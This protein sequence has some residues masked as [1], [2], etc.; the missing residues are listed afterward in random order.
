MIKLLP[1]LKLKRTMW[2]IQA[3]CF[4]LLM[5][6]AGSAVA[7]VSEEANLLKTITGKILDGDGEA[8][9]GA[10]IVEKGTGNGV[11]SDIDGM[12][13]ITVSD[14]CEFLEISYVGYKTIEIALDG[15]TNLE[16]SLELDQNLLNEVTVIGYGSSRKSDLTG[17][18]SSVKG[19]DLN[20]L[21]VQRV[22]QA[23]QGRAAG[24]VVQNT[25]GA[26][27]GGTLI[28]VRGANSINGGNSALVVVDGLQGVDIS[29]INPNDIASV[30]VL[31]DASATAIY[32]A[33]GANGVILITTK[34]GAT[35]KSTIQYNFS[36]GFQQLGRKVDL[37]NPA[38]YARKANL[39]ASTQ[40]G[41]PSA[42]IVPILPF[43]E[44]QISGL[45]AG[46]GTDWQ[47]E[48]FRNAT[49]FNHQLSASGGNDIARYYVSGGFVDQQGILINT[50]YRRYNLRSN[51]DV[52]LNSWLSAGF[53]LNI[54]KSNGNVP[55]FGEGTRFVDILGQ[56]INTVLRFDPA[57][58]VYDENGTYNYRA[59]RG[60]PSGSKIYADPDVWNPVATALETTSEKNTSVNEISTFL[61]FKLLKGL[62]FRV[63]GAAA[64]NNADGL[65]FY[66]SKTQPGR[67]ASG[68]G[69]LSE[70]T[71]QFFQNSNILTYSASINKKH[72]ITLT[73]VA[74]QQV[75][76][77]KGLLVSANGFFND[78]TGIY[79]LAG[80]SNVGEKTSYNTRTALNSFLGRANYVFNDKYILTASLR[81]DGSSVFGANNKWGYF[82]SV[83][84]AWRLIEEEFIKDLNVFSNLKIRGSWGVTG[85]QAIQPYQSI[86]ILGSGFNYSYLGD[87]GY[88]IGYAFSRPSNPN[89]RWESTAQTNV[90]LDLGFMKDR[91]T[92]SLDLYKKVTSDLLLNTRLENYTGFTS[93]LANVGSIEN[94][95]LEIAVGATPFV[96]K[97]F[98]WST[99]L[100]FSTNQSKVLELADGADYL[101]VRT[102]TGGGYNIWR[103][104]LLSLKQLRIGEPIDQMIGY[105]VLGTWGLDEATEA[106]KY[107]QAPGDIKFLDVNNDGQI[108]RADDGQEVIGNANPDFIF[109]WTNSLSYK[110]FDLNFLLQGVY[111]NQVFNATRIRTESA[112]Y[113]TSANLNNVWTPDNQNTNVAGIYYTSQQRLEMDL[114]PSRTADA[115]SG[116]DNRWSNYVED[117]SYLRLRNITLAYNLPTTLLSKVKIPKMSLNITAGN[118]FTLTKYSGYDPEVSSFNVRSEGGNGIDFSNYPSSRSIMFGLNITL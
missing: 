6:F 2:Y 27:G 44:A 36:G 94:Q 97:N 117:G 111:G 15:K 43:T 56:T 108:R 101:D 48:L 96:K 25:D 73:G 74:E 59:L 90:G 30:E 9:T 107:G 18:L 102:N 5:L 42:P 11:I 31:K 20:K 50:Q 55:P 54:I 58:P 38:D 47:D 71:Y 81:A 100:I 52:N 64:I 68:T 51:L 77:G 57:T 8:L 17:A 26:P 95:G 34:R 86:G 109:G 37:L 65:N 39:Y 80:A 35:A 14:N 89:L 118:L 88:N 92:V 1:Y 32:G 69:N 22:D 61:D 16:I 106:K 114:G 104:G 13:S 7:G 87:D 29:T 82:P 115:T 21:P 76:L 105:K 83:A 46:G 41:T 116:A 75:N 103:G 19:D 33:R 63:T 3:S 91:L 113:G 23:L 45:E 10:T 53:N 67:G 98:A 49:L 60:G 28:R 12:F 93:Q 84:A 24:V 4:L 78:L 79:D 70:D 112:A 40:N 99:N 66:N 110:G 72:N 85:N 62:T